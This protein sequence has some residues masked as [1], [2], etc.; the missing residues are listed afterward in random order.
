MRYKLLIFDVDDTLFDYSKTERRALQL[1]CNDYSID[2]PGDILYKN[3]KIANKTAHEEIGEITIENLP[4][5]RKMR[6][7]YFFS[8]LEIKCN[9]PD[10]FYK[11][12]LLY[13]RQGD[14]IDGVYDTLS[15]LDNRILV[16]ATNGTDFPRKDKLE[17]SIIASFF[18][19]F[20]SSE[21]LGVSKPHPAFLG[22]ILSKYDVSRKE[23]LVI[24]DSLCT[25]ILCAQ[26]IGV[27]SCWF[28]W[29][30]TEKTSDIV[31]PNYVINSFEELLLVLRE[32]N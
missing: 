28:N 6:I 5:F 1:V 23:V 18:N 7:K 30:K 27:H 17:N 12:M 22:T 19:A 32:N 29:K 26:N 13:S 4:L 21:S 24:G 20:Y 9:E 16:A 25:D 2:L 11:T 8:L 10:V 31:V 14:L 3:Y 15:V